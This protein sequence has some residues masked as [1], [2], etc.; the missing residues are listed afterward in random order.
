MTTS[1]PLAPVPAPRQVTV[2][3]GVDLAVREWL[4]EKAKPDA[5]PFVLLHGLASNSLMWAGVARR[6]AEAGHVAV[7]VDLRGHGL[8][9]KPD[10]GYDVTSIA[11]EVAALL[12]A[13]DLGRPIVAGQSW[14]GNVVLELGYRH[15]SVVAGVVGVDGGMIHLR[16]LHPDW[17]ECRRWKKPPPLTGTLLSRFE[18]T[19]RVANSDWPEEGIRGVLGC[20]EV[21]DDETIAPWLSPDRHIAVLRG[22]WEHEPRQ[23]YADVSVPVLWL[24]AD[25]G[26]SEWLPGKRAAIEE[27]ER[28]LPRS[29]TH[30]FAPAHHDVHAQQP[31]AVTRVLLATH[32]EGF[33]TP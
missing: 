14:G 16:E 11:D 28:M 30:W 4:P 33:F 21:R 29:R 5:A 2:A 19:I 18:A 12:G 17:E 8:S 23:F 24:P 31:E 22:M 32:D 25:S 26:K 7:A 20:F 13:L 27:A 15:P 1:P 9:S 10:G 3:D 6:L